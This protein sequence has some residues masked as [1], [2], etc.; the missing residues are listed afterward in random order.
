MEAAYN[1]CYCFH[2]FSLFFQF[3]FVS[4]F[5]SN[6]LIRFERW[7]LSKRSRADNL[8][9]I[10]RYRDCSELYFLSLGS[11]FHVLV[12]AVGLYSDSFYVATTLH[13]IFIWYYVGDFHVECVFVVWG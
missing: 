2:K 8:K 13:V 1:L 3:P 4:F 9:I 11:C 12:S 7:L 6:N 5:Q 10:S